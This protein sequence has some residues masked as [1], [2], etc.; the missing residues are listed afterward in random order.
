M[1]KAVYIKEHPRSYLADELLT[2]DWTNDTEIEIIG[3]LDAPSDIRSN[4]AKALARSTR[5]EYVIGGHRQRGTEGWW[6]AVA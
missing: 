5:G 1:T 3:G 6:M 2:N 4:L